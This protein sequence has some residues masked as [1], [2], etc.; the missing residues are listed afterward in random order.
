M[1]IISAPHPTLRQVAH[2]V[3]KFDKRLAKFVEHLKKQLLLEK[4]PEGVGLAAPQVNKSWQIFVLRHTE[5]D[6]T[7][8]DQT[9]SNQTEQN[10]KSQDQTEQD[11]PQKSKPDDKLDQLTAFINPKIIAHSQKKTL[12]KETEHFEGCLSVPKIYGPVPR[13]AWVEVTYQTFSQTGELETKQE[14][15]QGFLARIIQHEYDHL[16]G[17]LF[18]DHLLENGLPA[19]VLI[20]NEWVELEDREILASF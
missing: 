5:H 3:T 6:L 10:Q 12:L 4:D 9:A 14:K 20:K 1:K 18:T 8:N 7:E 13:W 16:Q 15:Y 11:Q 19:Y 17:V 2:P